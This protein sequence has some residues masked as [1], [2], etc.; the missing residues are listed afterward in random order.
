MATAADWITT[1][2]LGLDKGAETVW[3]LRGDWTIHNVEAIDRQLQRRLASMN[4]AD[5]LLSIQLDLAAL[6][7]LDS[8]GAWLVT[9]LA[10][11]ARAAGTTV[12]LHNID[13][14]MQDLLQ[15][16]IDA[17][18]DQAPPAPPRRTLSDWIAQI[19][20]AVCEIWDQSLDLLAF[21]GA[22]A[23]IFMQSMLRPRQLR[24]NSIVSHIEQTGLNAMPIVGLIS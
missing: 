13:P 14:K 6:T 21:F 22:F 3:S 18:P 9:R 11:D 23:T 12:E 5:R 16:V 2:R 15:R 10:R 4:K 1:T 7:S 19:G 24:F 17:A 8:A 20:E